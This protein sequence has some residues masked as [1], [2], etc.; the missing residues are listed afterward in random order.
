MTQASSVP[1]TPSRTITG[2]TL[3][4]ALFSAL[5][6][7]ALVL[8]LHPSLAATASRCLTSAIAALFEEPVA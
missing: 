5:V 7:Q 4:W 8:L 1:R 3:L 2:R 6:L